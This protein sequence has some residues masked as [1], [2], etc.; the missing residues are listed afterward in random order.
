MD[1]SKSI[2]EYVAEQKDEL[3]LFFKNKKSTLAIIQIGDNQASNTYIRGKKKDASEIGVNVI[4]Y[5]YSENITQKKLVSYIKKLNKSK[6]I[7]GIILQLPI[8]KHLCYDELRNIIS[9]KKDVDGFN[10]LSHIIPCTPYGICLYLKYCHFDFKNKN[11][12]IIG[13]SDIVGKPMAKLLLEQNCNTTILHSKTSDE[14]KQYFL[15][16]ADLIVVAT[17]KINTVTKN[18]KLKKSA[19]IIDVGINRDENNHLIGDCERDLDVSY[20][21]PV[22]GGVG[23]LTR[24][25]IFKNLQKLIE[26]E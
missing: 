12:V 15:Q 3:S 11:A 14:N 21:S 7:N 4:H 26:S 18:M 10:K 16:N 20:Q 9:V 23:L 25:A 17:G 6:K 13:R 5:K 22:P 8:P 24:I 19:V 2:K 1:F